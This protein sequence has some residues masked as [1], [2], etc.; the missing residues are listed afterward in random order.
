MDPITAIGLAIMLIRGGIQIYQALHD[1][2]ATPEATKA[3]L[4]PLITSAQGHVTLLE[5]TRDT[6]NLTQEV[7]SP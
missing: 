7:Q 3:V 4:R 1:H 5:H 6:L 2:P